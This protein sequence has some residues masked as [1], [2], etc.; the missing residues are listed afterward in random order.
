M[1]G[2]SALGETSELRTQSLTYQGVARPLDLT[3]LSIIYGLSY[4]I[5]SEQPSIWSILMR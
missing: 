3:A 5:P 2:S 4:L 1:P